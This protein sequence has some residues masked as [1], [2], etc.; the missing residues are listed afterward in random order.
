MV[1]F[2]QLL[3]LLSLSLQTSKARWVA[4][5][6]AHCESEEGNIHLFFME[7]IGSRLAVTKVFLRMLFLGISGT[8][9]LSI[10][11]EEKVLVP[12]RRLD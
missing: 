10:D 5:E 11:A 6:Y 1:F 7:V 2:A 3:S 4:A 12:F 8:S 9:G